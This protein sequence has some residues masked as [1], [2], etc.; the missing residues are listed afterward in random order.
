MLAALVCHDV[1]ASN[2]SDCGV[3]DMIALARDT[4][5]FESRSRKADTIRRCLG[6]ELAFYAIEVF[7]IELRF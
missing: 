4:H 5:K 7:K 3:S 6:A 1:F 2:A